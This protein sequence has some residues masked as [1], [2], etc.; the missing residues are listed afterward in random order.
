MGFLWDGRATPRDFPREKPEGN[1]EEQPF[2]PEENPV[3]PNS[4][5]WIYITF[6]MDF[7][8]V[9][10]NTKMQNRNYFSKR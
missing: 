1:P 9:Q 10:N 2:Q 8:I 3:F 4:F 6:Q 5:T 7:F